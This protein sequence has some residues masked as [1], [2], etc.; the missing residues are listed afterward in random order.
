M[1]LQM[2]S[3][4][5][6]PATRPER[7]AKAL[8][9][10]A[11]AVI[12]DLEDAVEPGAKSQ[13]RQHVL[14]F[15]QGQPAAIFWVRLNAAATPWFDDDLALCRQ[16]GNIGGVLLPKA[17]SAGQVVQAMA[18]GKPVIPLIENA[19]GVIALSEIAAVE[20]VHCI[21]FGSLD[22]LLDLGATPDTAGAQLLLNQLRCQVLVQ[23][24]VHGLAAP[25]D[26]VYPN[27]A[28]EAGL[29]LLAQQVRDM[30]FGG[31][32][33][34]HPKQIA[35]IHAAFV[36]TADQIDWARRVVAIASNTESF[37]F[38]VDGEMVDLPVIE[39]ARQIIQTTDES[40][41]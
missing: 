1:T 29:A 35:P 25:L 19:R 5:F 33:C 10:G 27:F 30:G 20:G 11:D 39:R 3:A 17:E 16:F 14:E 2:R 6:V 32:L 36:P 8:A 40:G 18:A 15:A 26:G 7:F 41:I 13:A 9:A 38:K 37:A 12:I 24:R 4:L 23:S 22:L 31:M 21:S 28:D 34:I